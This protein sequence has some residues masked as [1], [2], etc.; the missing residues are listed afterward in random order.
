MRLD[1]ILLLFK[2]RSDAPDGNGSV[3]RNRDWSNSR[4]ALARAKDGSLR[5]SGRRDLAANV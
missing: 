4:A 5:A 1:G 2:Q 3:E